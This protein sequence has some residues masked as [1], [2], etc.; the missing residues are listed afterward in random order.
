M[1]QPEQTGIEGN[2]LYRGVPYRFPSLDGI[3]RKFWPEQIGIDIYALDCP[4]C[5]DLLFPIDQQTARMINIRLLF[6]CTFGYKSSH[7]GLVK[8]HSIQF[9]V[10]KYFFGKLD[11]ETIQF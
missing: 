8:P 7:P 6:P 10:T 11:T 3:F 4:N 5:L 1:F 2:K 9:R